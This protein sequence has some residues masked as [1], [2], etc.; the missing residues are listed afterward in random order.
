MFEIE[1]RFAGVPISQRSRTQNVQEESAG[2]LI[3]YGSVPRKRWGHMAL[4]LHQLAW[5]GDSS[6]LVIVSSEVLFYLICCG[7][8]PSQHVN[9]EDAD[10][11]D[12]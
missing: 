1:F 4:C 3:F 8:C 7:E 9:E 12:F 2:L 10:L 11:G 6:W 5:V